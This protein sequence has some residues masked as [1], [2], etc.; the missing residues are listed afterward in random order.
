MMDK[1]ERLIEMMD[2]PD[3]YSQEEW[4]EILADEDCRE[5][6][7]LMCDTSA[8]LNGQKEDDRLRSDDRETEK[9]LRHF[10]QRYM[11]EERRLKTWRQ[12][13]AVFAGLL[14]VSGIA[15]AAIAI[16]R[17][18]RAATGDAAEVI[19]AQPTKS[20]STSPVAK[21]TAVAQPRTEAAMKQ[22]VDV[23]VDNILKEIAAYYG[24]KE[25][26][27]S[28]QAAHTRLYFNWNKQYDVR[29]VVEQLNQFDHIHITLNGDNLVLEAAG[30]TDQ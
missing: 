12:V 22:F 29:Q 13:A 18:Q 28:S 10:R 6:Y 16:V 11:P 4:R 2:R 7:R 14:L 23:P 27:R 15:F 30:G 1:I 26:T 19:M 9:A 17:Q 20:A 21:D 8:A 25:E 3:R 5:Y 24:L